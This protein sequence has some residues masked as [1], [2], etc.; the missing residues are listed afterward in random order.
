MAE[1]YLQ[2]I[3]SIAM[4]NALRDHCSPLS[5]LRYVDDSHARF[6]SASQVD[7]F[8]TELNSQD[9]CIQYTVEKEEQ[10]QLAF[11]DVNIINTRHGQYEFKVHRK[12]AI[13]NVQLKPH[14]SINPAIFHAVFKGFLVRA[15][16]T[17]STK[18]LQEEIQFLIDVFAE[19]GHERSSLEK[20]VEQHLNPDVSRRNQESRKSVI[21]IPWIPQLGPKLR[22][23]Y[24]KQ[25]IK[26]VFTS[27]PSISDI[28]CNHKSRLPS[29]SYPGVYKVLCRCHQA[30][31]VGETKKQ[32]STRIIEHE[33]DVFHGRWDKSGLS[34]HAKVCCESFDFENA[35]TLAIEGDFRLRKIRE[36]LEI[37]MHETAPNL[38][39]ATN[40]DR[41]NILRSE[42]WNAL[43]KKIR[44]AKT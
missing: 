13:T 24:R 21:K 25:G 7:E 2:H 26:T 8:L 39:M 35:K 5:F 9:S 14:S 41:G 37:R 23:I 31:Y 15:S 27:A 42:T 43:M 10:G 32:V 3:E 20:M 6:N 11:L 19:N 38:S 29:N 44:D 40:K 1:G 28:L 22:K 16:R 33:R 17:C 18:H 36:A 4:N 34:E 30:A 12:D